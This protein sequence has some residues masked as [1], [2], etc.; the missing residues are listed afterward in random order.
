MTGAGGTSSSFTSLELRTTDGVALVLEQIAGGLQ[1]PVDVAVASDGALFVAE[2]AGTVRVVRD[3]ILALEPAL[4]VAS[5]L[6]APDGGLL[7]IALDARFDDTHFLYALY[8][9]AAP[10]DAIEVILSRFRGVGD[11]FAERAVLLTRTLR[12]PPEQQAG[13]GAVSGALRVGADGKL[14]VGVDGEILRLNSDATTPDDHV[15]FTPV[16]SP[17][18]PMPRALDWHP[19]SSDLW[20][21][22]QVDPSGGRLATAVP[23][24]AG[25]RRAVPRVA[26][27]LPVGTGATSAAFYR[28][29]A[30][31][32]FHGDLFV[33]ASQGR[34]LM[35][36]RFDPNNATRIASV[37]RLLTDQ[38]GPV[39]VVAD[40]RDGAL[41]VAS[42]NAVYRLGP[43]AE[44][45]SGP[46]A[47]PGSRV[48]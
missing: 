8:A 10:R 37:E 3:G 48:R 40:A 9:S 25:Q 13:V 28:N 47:L 14:Y 24:F 26:Y 29:G 44:S 27:R 39:Q 38:I 30:I 11:R 12:S 35:R 31:P 20:V 5:D 18:H 15:P 23:I 46:G 36:L 19:Q 6:A 4:D 21:V 32:N 17:D 7:A 16:Y 45:A 33:A 22:E 43:T 42:D 1:E 41:Y 2:R 34:Q